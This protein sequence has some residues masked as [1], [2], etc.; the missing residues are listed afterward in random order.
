MDLERSFGSIY[1]R[2]WLRPGRTAF[3]VHGVNQQGTQGSIDAALT[4]GILWLDQCRNSAQRHTLV[5]GLKLVLPPGTSALTREHLVHLHPGAAKWQLYEF[6]ERHDSLAEVDFGDRGNVVP[7][8]VRCP[9]ESATWERFSESIHR[10]LAL[11]PECDV[12]VLS[13]AEV[14][15]SLARTGVCTGADQPRGRILSQR[16]GVCVWR[17]RG[18]TRVRGS[19]SGGLQ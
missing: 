9:D 2:G 11:L 14:A 15:F 1:A 4:F 16:A 12:A 5:E 6:D 19:Q 18:R 13:A 3:A 8:L 17:R 7:R 10:S